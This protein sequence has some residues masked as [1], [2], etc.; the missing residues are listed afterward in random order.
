MVEDL[1]DNLHALRQSDAIIGRLWVAAA[2]RR[3]ALLALAGL[4]GVLG[5]A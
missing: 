5:S 2:T 1:V 3:L 4:V